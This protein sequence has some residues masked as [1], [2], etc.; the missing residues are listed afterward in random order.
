[1]TY[2]LPS[3]PGAPAG[4]QWIY[5]G[6]VYGYLFYYGAAGPWKTQTSRAL[7]TP[8]GGVTD[9]YATKILWHV[10]GGSG[11]VTINGQRLD[12]PGH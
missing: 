12:E 9:R 8:S 6:S 11:A 4:V 5:A 3:D 7:I 1:M 2:A 10:P